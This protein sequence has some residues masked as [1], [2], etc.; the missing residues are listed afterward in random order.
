MNV[1]QQCQR[2]RQ[3]REK[4]WNKSFSYFVES[5]VQCTLH[6]KI[7]F[8]LIFNF[9][10]QASYYRQDSLIVGV[11]DTGEQFFGG[12]VDTGEK[13]QAFWLFPCDKN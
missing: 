12:V 3:K 1:Y 10:V 11:I 9:Q 4:F 13:F 6:L 5:L 2:Y 7:E 8:L